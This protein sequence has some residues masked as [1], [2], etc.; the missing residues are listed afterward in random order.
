[1]PPGS[2]APQVTGGEEDVINVDVSG[3]RVP[4]R[5]RRHSDTH[6]GAVTGWWGNPDGDG[7]VGPDSN[8]TRSPASSITS[9]TAV[10]AGISPAST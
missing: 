2:P 3:G 5:A 8:R 9:R 10:S 4:V 7:N 1:M 6:Q